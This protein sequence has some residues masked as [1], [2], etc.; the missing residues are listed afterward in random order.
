MLLIAS[1][2]ISH[3]PSRLALTHSELNCE[4]LSRGDLFSTKQWQHIQNRRL[5]SQGPR[6]PFSPT[7][8]KPD[9]FLT[10]MNGSSTVRHTSEVLSEIK[11]LLLHFHSDRHTCS[12]SHSFQTTAP[13]F[14]CNTS[15]CMAKKER[16]HPGQ[17]ASILKLKQLAVVVHC[18]WGPRS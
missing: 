3:L 10:V 5:F 12:C 15:L 8:T 2:T 17:A 9:W 14:P 11:M 6:S 4:T 16:I 7:N 13:L 1:Q 18:L